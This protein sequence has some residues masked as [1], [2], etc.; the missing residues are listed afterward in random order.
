MRRFLAFA[1]AFTVVASSA[2]AQNQLI[3][4]SPGQ[5]HAQVTPPQPIRNPFPMPA[6]RYE[7]TVSKVLEKLR[8]LRPTGPVTQSDINKAI[9]LF[10]DCSSNIEADG[11]VTMGEMKHCNQVLI[12]FKRER[13]HEI[14]MSSSPDEWGQ[15]ARQSGAGQ[16]QQHH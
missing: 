15:W 7:A 1:F 5:R 11:Y 2:S 6:A 12:N 14:M 10:R 8:H 9:L 4:G 3:T 16:H 13:Q